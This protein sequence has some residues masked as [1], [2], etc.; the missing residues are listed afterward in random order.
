MPLGMGYMAKCGLHV[1]ASLAE[2]AE[3]LVLA[4]ET[5]CL[6]HQVEIKMIVH[7]LRI[8]TGKGIL[9]GVY[10]IMICTRTSR[11]TS[12]HVWCNLMDTAYADVVRQQT[13]KFHSERVRLEVGIR[14]EMGS[15]RAGMNTSIGAS[16][17]RHTNGLAQKQREA[18]LQFALHRD[19]IGLYLPP[20]IPFAIVAKPNE[21]AH[22]FKEAI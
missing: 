20:M 4:K 21:I 19:A 5:P 8:A 11:E 15:H 6:V 9:V 12:V 17:P 18:T 13:I 2:S 22:I 1:A 3:V 10:I 7:L 14:I 16:G